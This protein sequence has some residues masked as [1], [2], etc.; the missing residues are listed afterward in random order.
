[1]RI[2][3]DSRFRGNDNKGPMTTFYEGVTVEDD[4]M[5]LNTYGDTM[6]HR[7]PIKPRAGGELESD[8]GCVSEA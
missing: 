4:D 5:I 8:V 3:V 2:S 7:V 1:M 6:R